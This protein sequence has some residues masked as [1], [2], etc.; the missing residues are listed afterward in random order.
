MAYQE[1]KQSYLNQGTKPQ[2]RIRLSE[3]ENVVNDFI[4]LEDGTIVD[5]FELVFAMFLLNRNQ[6]LVLAGNHA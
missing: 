2:G 3:N 5:R 6:Q 1:V 4:E